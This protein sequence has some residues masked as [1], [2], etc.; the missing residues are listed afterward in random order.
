MHKFPSKAVIKVNTSF[1]VTE[2]EMSQASA[3]KFFRDMSKFAVILFKGVCI[4]TTV[5]SFL[6]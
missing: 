3:I 4:K 6:S 1:F 2:I 5:H